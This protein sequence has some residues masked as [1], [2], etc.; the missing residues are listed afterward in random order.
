MW[1]R[2]TNAIDNAFYDRNE[3]THTHTHTTIDSDDT[4]IEYKGYAIAYSSAYLHR[5]P[6]NVQVSY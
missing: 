3:H 6:Y 2:L 1:G 5:E 4:D